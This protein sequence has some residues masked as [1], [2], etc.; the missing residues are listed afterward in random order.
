VVLPASRLEALLAAVIELG[1]GLQDGEALL[2][3]LQVNT[4]PAVFARLLFDQRLAVGGRIAAE[5]AQAE[6]V[7]SLE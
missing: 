3:R 2:G 6:A 5:Q 1:R 7:L 4:R